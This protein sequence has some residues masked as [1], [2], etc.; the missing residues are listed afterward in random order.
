MSE[1]EGLEEHDYF[2]PRP[3]RG[4]RQQ[5]QRKNL[6]LLFYYISFCTN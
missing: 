4:G 3:P 6:L 5:K 1:L 2:Y